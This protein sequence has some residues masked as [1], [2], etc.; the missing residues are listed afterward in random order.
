MARNGERRPP[1]PQIAS[2]EGA[3]NEEEAAAIAAALQQFAAETAPAPA[4]AEAQSRW[5]TAA[6]KEGVE[7]EPD[8]GSWGLR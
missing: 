3:P 1:R 5:L 8:R 2:I 4:K 7:R 6:L